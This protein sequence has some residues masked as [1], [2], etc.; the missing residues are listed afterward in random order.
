M[1][2]DASSDQVQVLEL[3]GEVADLGGVRRWTRSTLAGLH[4]DELVDVLLVV[5]E[6]VSNVYDHSRFPA[7]LRLNRSAKPCVVTISVDDASATAP[8]LRQSSSDSPRGR[9]MVIV[10]RLAKQWGVV[11]HAIGKSV[12]ALIPCPLTS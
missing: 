12:W 3:N 10:N 6:L 1:N 9:G 11:Q 8:V 7:R 5:T 2:T 4:P